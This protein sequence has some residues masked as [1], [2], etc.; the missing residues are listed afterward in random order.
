KSIQLRPDYI[1]GY[2]VLG[3]ILQKLTC[4]SSAVKFYKKAISLD[5]KQLFSILS[6]SEQYLIMGNMSM[7]EKYFRKAETISPDWFFVL[8]LGGRLELLKKNYKKADQYFNKYEEKYQSAR[9]YFHGYILLKLGE[10]AVGQGI[11]DNELKE[12]LE[13]AKYHPKGTSRTENA[14]AEIYA[15]NGDKENAFKWLNKAI[16]KGWIDYRY[17]LIYPYFKSVKKEKQFDDLIIKMKTKIDSMKAIII[18]SDP[19]PE[20]C[21]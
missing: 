19:D 3:S 9:E 18:E 15:I 1:F 12:Y 5:P 4:D 16:N 7:A 14:I 6:L 20:F 21:E 17:N 10:T 11:I 13:Y 8:F 2:V